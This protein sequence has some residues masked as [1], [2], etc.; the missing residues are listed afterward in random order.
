MER[1][2][3]AV[4]CNRRLF[5]VFILHLISL[6]LTSFLCL[7]LHYVYVMY[8]M[9]FIGRGSMDAKMEADSNDITECLH[10]DEPIMGMLVYY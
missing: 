3:A 7:M 6:F 4:T 2:R 5:N 10:D 9:V 1:E 8:V